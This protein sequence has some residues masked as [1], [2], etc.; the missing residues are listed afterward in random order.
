VKCVFPPATGPRAPSTLGPMAERSPN[1]DRPAFDDVDRSLVLALQEDGRASYAKLAE[2]VGMSQAGVRT[3]VQRL[4]SSEAVQ[5]AAV[6]DPFAFGFNITGMV[7]ITYTGDLGELGRAV[8]AIEGVHFVAVVAGRYD[9][10]AEIVCIDNDDLLTLVNDRIRAIPGVKDV[11]VI[12]YLKLFK[13]WQPEYLRE[14]RPSHLDNEPAT[15]PS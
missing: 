7:G 3:R 14:T 6:A 13:Q 9:C 8:A 10:L 11:D 2:L 1:G 5:I 12:T 15:R 4:L